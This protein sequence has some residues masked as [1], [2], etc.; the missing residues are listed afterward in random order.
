MSLYFIE[1]KCLGRKISDLNK[2]LML[3][4]LWNYFAYVEWQLLETGLYTLFRSRFSN[5]DTNHIPS[6][7]ITG[8]IKLNFSIPVS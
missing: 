1:L 2:N 5:L 7:F 6:R 3:V 8:K 4:I